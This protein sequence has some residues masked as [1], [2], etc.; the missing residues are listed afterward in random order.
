MTK[1]ERVYRE[2]RQRVET[3]DRGMRFPSVRQVIRELGVSQVTVDRA[4]DRLSEEG[5]IVRRPKRG[6]FIAGDDEPGREVSTRRIGVAIPDYPS[7]VYE[8]Y[9][10][11]MMRQVDAAGHMVRL[12]RYSWRDRVPR[13]LTLERLDGLVLVPTGTQFHPEDIYRISR[14]GVP[15]V[16]M[17]RLVPGVV[18]DC[19]GPDNEGGGAL[20]ASHLIELGHRRLA[21]LV[22]EPRGVTL[23]ARVAGFRRQVEASGLAS[24]RVIDGHV[25][26]GESA[27]LRACL[28][29]KGEIEREGVTFT[30]LFVVSDG[31]AIGALKALHDGGIGIPDQ[32]SVV[33]FG[34]IPEAAV[35]HPS[36]TTIREDTAAMAHAAVEIIERRLD[37]DQTPAIQRVLAPDLVVRES[38]GAVRDC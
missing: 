20:A 6:I 37:G 19:V 4:L 5:L 11:H 31:S 33:G 27:A 8:S 18:M 7:P 24:P 23:E 26:P 2:L 15:V 34:D 29:L 30:G 35:Y 21:V 17:E 25:E 38:T 16:L 1:A 14:M 3:M 36:L 32:V 9:A 12:L 22:C 13:G 28:V 10:R